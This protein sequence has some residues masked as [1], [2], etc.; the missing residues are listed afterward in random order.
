MND[1]EAIKQLKARYCRTMDTKD[2]D[3]MRQVFAD[4]AVIDT[5]A[6]G[7]G[8]VTG[9]EEFMTFLREAL[10]DVVSVHHC[11]TPEIT[12]TSPSTAAGIWA[13]E[14][15]LRWA[16][17]RELIGFGH[18]HE[19]YDKTGGVWR[20]RT[21]TLTRLRMDLTEPATSHPGESA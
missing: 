4:D 16:D 18:Y 17:G 9:A 3:A 15:R 19:T 5:T 11:H 7:G 12:L 14:D 1:L 2:W 8:T 10:A 6:S 13:M 20:I 21:S